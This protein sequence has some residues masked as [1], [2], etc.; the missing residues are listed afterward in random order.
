MSKTNVVL[1]CACDK[2]KDIATPCCDFF[3]DMLNDCKVRLEYRPTFR[4]FGI[5]LVGGGGLQLI[6][7]CPWCGRKLPTELC[8]EWDDVIKKEYNLNPDKISVE[9]APKEMQTDEWWKKR[10]L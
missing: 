1:E 8:A 10:E 5:K 7:Y 3:K 2:F 9:E 6:Y 4:E